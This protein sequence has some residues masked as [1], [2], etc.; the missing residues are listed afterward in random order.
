MPANAK[1]FSWT[2]QDPQT[3]TLPGM[4]AKVN[5]A[6]RGLSHDL[7]TG[8]AATDAHGSIRLF[9]VR[10]PV[11]IPGLA[12]LFLDQADGGLKVQ[13]GDGVLKILATDP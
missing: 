6:L 13:F 4:V 7:A 5:D 11:A 2:T 9:P 3:I 10:A 12:Q 1:S 8:G